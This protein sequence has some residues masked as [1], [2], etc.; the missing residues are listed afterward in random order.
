[1]AFHAQG[2]DMRT[3]LREGAAF[4]KEHMPSLPD[5]FYAHVSALPGPR[6]FLEHG[7]YHKHEASETQEAT[8]NSSNAIDLICATSGQMN[9][10]TAAVSVAAE[11]QANSVAKNI[12]KRPADS[13][14]TSEVTQSIVQMNM[15][16]EAAA[17]APTRFWRL[18]RVLRRKRK[19]FADWLTHSSQGCARPSTDHPD[20][21]QRD[22]G[23]MMNLDL[24][25]QDAFV[26]GI[27]QR[28]AGYDRQM[29]DGLDGLLSSFGEIHDQPGLLWWQTVLLSARNIIAPTGPAT[30]EGK[31]VREWVAQYLVMF[32]G[33]VA[34]E[35]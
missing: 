2:E 3:A 26:L 20:L 5:G 24:N 9:A 19:S 4:L 30:D 13:A 29:I 7:S 22:N 31:R 8:A 14:A 33:Q 11:Q 12:V 34:S 17:L 35:P 1:M 28:I 10:Y 32:R 15:A 18:R 16:R 25:L 21:C 23:V 6:L 27:E